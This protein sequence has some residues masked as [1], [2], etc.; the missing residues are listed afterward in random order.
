MAVTS[1]L[2]HA[3]RLLGLCASLH[4][5]VDPSNHIWYSS[6]VEA[7]VGDLDTM[8]SLKLVSHSRVVSFV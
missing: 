8:L 2:L 7:I 3:L 4:D 6:F 5:A 1:V